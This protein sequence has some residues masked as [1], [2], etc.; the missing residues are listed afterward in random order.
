MGLELDSKL[1]E[2]TEMGTSGE[3]SSSCGNERSD[4]TMSLRRATKHVLSNRWY[5]VFE[6]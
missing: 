3:K 6:R 4:D 1:C 2:K 5:V